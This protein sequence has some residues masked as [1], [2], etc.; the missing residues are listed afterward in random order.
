MHMAL[1]KSPMHVEAK[2]KK[3]R[4]PKTRR[5]LF[6]VPASKLPAPNDG[7][8]NGHASTKMHI[9]SLTQATF[10][11]GSAI[12]YTIFRAFLISKGERVIGFVVSRH[13]LPCSLWYASPK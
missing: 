5:V 13:L 8:I 10:S 3:T 4:W 11:S 1:F 7:G 6:I 2:K 12:S 9:F